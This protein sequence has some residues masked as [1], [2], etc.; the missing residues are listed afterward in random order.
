[1]YT[2]TSLRSLVLMVAVLFPGIASAAESA[3]ERPPE[4]III[5]YSSISGN[6]APLWV[7]H[8]RGFFRKYGLDAQLVFIESGTTTVQS[9]ISKDVA[10]AQMAGAGV[11]QSR[12][13]GS[14]VVMIA[15]V[16]NTLTFKFYVDK[17]IKQPDQLKGKT[18]AV[19]RFG[20]STDFALRYALDRYGLAPEKDVTI[21]QV[22]NMAAILA[23]L[24]T[25]RIQG[26]M[27]SAPFTLRAKN[28]GFPLMADLQM[29]GLEYQHT[30]LATTQ[31]LIKSRPDLVRNAMKAYVEGIHYYKTHRAESLAILAKYLKTTDS[32]ILTE[33]YEDVGLKLTAEKP[34]PTLRGIEIMLRELAATSPKP[35]AARPEEFVDLTFI[36]ELD[37]SG[38]IDRL[39]KTTTVVASREEQRPAPAPTSIKEKSAP[40]NEKT[41]P[42]MG[43]AKSFAILAPAAGSRE[44]TVEPGDTLSYIARKYYGSHL[45]WDKIYQANKP[46]MK[47]P[48]YIYVGQIIIIPS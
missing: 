11:V 1:M 21:L 37:S 10:F 9:L 2:R 42:I 12:L 27:L 3:A 5:A 16:I 47:N 24:E 28:M 19:T 7:T 31:A 35:T 20:S 4:K 45:K 41:K 13:R 22:G 46:I 6:M 25:G 40:A 43:T 32:D 8:D 29:L 15:G 38:F 26:A 14:D 18:V 30:G 36:K 17:N 34:Y 23:S 48:D 39:Y 33:V 44:Y